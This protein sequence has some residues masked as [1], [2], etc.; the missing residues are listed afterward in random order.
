LIVGAAKVE[1]EAAATA[2]ATR[3]FS[4]AFFIGLSNLLSF[5]A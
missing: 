2:V 4:I 1:T 3:V 5:H